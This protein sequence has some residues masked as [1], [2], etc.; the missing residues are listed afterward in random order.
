MFF[1]DLCKLIEISF[2]GGQVCFKLFS[3]QVSTGFILVRSNSL[4]VP[5]SEVRFHIISSILWLWQTRNGWKLYGV[6]TICYQWGTQIVTCLAYKMRF[7]QAEPRPLRHVQYFSIPFRDAEYLEQCIS[8]DPL[9]STQWFTF[10]YRIWA[11]KNSQQFDYNEYL[12]FWN[13]NCGQKWYYCPRCF[14]LFSCSISPH[15]HFPY[16]WLFVMFS[17]ITNIDNKKTPNA[18]TE[19]STL[20]FS[21]SIAP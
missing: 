14:L 12:V 16:T 11:V 4:K 3:L 7:I 9:M 5:S 8:K 1:Q 20:L 21:T 17:V 10:C 6:S 19:P 15:T 2:W 18:Y 13:I